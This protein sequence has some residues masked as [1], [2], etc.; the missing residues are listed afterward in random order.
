MIELALALGFG[1]FLAYSNGANDN[2]KGVATLFGSG[3]TDERKALAWATITTALGSIVALILAHG[4]LTTFSGKGLV[5]DSVVAMKSFAL[6]VALSAAATVFLA[7]RFGLPV[8]TT[9]ALTG[10]LAGA[11]WLASPTGI[12]LSKLGSSFFLPLLASPFLAIFAAFFIYPIFR[13]ARSKLGVERETCLCVG[14][15]VVAV[16]P[17]GRS[18]QEAAA[19]YSLAAVPSITIGQD[20]TCRDR[21]DGSV[22]GFNAARVL[23]VSHYLS[24]GIV[25]FARGL[26]DTPKIAAILLAGA[27]LPSSAAIFLVAFAMALGGI[28]QSHRVAYTMSKRITGMNA[29]QGFTA[30]LVTGG[31]VILASKLGLP[32]STTHVSCGALFGIGTVTRQARWKTILSILLAWLTTLPLAAVLGMIFFTMLKG[33]IQ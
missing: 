26:N 1:A 15:E 14:T 24:A 32:V 16:I 3:T 18:V 10:A 25:S 28:L 2:F 5:P 33:W 23:D 13:A 11:G 7:T 29:G 22:L 12:S 8:S 27:A 9:H 20:A 19:L 6:A 17:P 4:L 31:I 30:N 21:Y